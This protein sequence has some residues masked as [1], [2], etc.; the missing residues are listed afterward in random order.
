LDW[1][2][3]LWELEKHEYWGYITN[4]G[5]E[6]NLHGV[7]VGFVP[8][9]KWL[10]V[11]FLS[12]LNLCSILLTCYVLLSLYRR[13]VFPD[14]I[15]YTSRE[16]HYSIFKAARMYR[17]KLEKVDTLISGEIDCADFRQRLLKNKDKPA[18][19]NVNIGKFRCIIFRCEKSE[20]KSL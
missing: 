20:C 14:G 17:M 10:L 1:F 7:L 12:I 11:K 18:I 3:R 16:T 6:G 8:V 4:C 13:E 5:T 2:A 9:L 15:L 19:V